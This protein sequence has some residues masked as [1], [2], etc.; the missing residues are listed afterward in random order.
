[1][2]LPFLPEALRTLAYF[3]DLPPSQQTVSNSVLRNW[4][5]SLDDRTPT[6]PLAVGNAETW[7]NRQ[8]RL[9]G[10]AV[11]SGSAS[12]FDVFS[13]FWLESWRGGMQILCGKALKVATNCYFCKNCTEIPIFFSTLKNPQLSPRQIPV[14][15]YVHSRRPQISSA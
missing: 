12:S 6:N 7:R 5:M 9:G 8:N 15:I 2:L 10:L 11:S 1:M 4:H 3:F 14:H 13:A